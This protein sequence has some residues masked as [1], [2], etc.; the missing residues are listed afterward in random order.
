M[1][2]YRIVE[3]HKKGKEYSLWSFYSF[4]ECYSKLLEMIENQKKCVSNKYYVCNDFYDNEYEPFFEDLTKFTI[5]VREVT[6]WKDY[7]ENTQQKN[8]N[9]L[10]FHKI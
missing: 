5:Q 9:I 3:Q 6:N 10:F 1:L 7:K 4:N 2:E 8:N